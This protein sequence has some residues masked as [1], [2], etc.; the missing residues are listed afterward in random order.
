MRMRMQAQKRELQ[1]NLRH[2][3]NGGHGRNQKL[4]AFKRLQ[5]K[6]KNW[7][8]L[9]NHIFSKSIIEYALKNKAGVIQMERLTG[10]G[11]NKNDEVD[12]GYKFILRYWSFFE[13]QT[14]IEYKA[15]AAG[16]EVRYIEPRYTSQ[17]C[18]FCGHYE[19]GQR[20]NQQTFI[21]KNPDCTKGK[22][23]QEKDGTYKGINADW[24]AARNIALS[25]KVVDRK[26]K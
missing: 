21:C 23:K 1:R 11:R 20:I 26:K 22:G 10:F 13:L 24:N 9:Q 15:N 8:R 18:S 17:T 4:Q 2:T 14:M 16:I 12:E 6:E 7:V 3:T 5:D 19:K 25:K